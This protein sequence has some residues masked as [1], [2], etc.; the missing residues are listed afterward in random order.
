MLDS[1]NFQNNESLPYQTPKVINEHSWVW[2]FVFY[3]LV[4]LGFGFLACH[5]ISP[6]SI[7]QFSVS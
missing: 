4:W 5:Y 1:I 7:L 3:L 6:H 2:G